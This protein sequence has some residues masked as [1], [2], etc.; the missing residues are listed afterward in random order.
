MK[1]KIST[2]SL[3]FASIFFLIG[4][5]SLPTLIASWDFS[6]YGNP[7]QDLVFLRDGWR[8]FQHNTP[9][10]S[11][12][13]GA[14]QSLV[15]AFVI[16]MQHLCGMFSDV[17]HIVPSEEELQGIF[18]SSKLT[19]FLLY[20]LLITIASIRV[21]YLTDAYT[22]LI[23]GC[24]IAVS[25]GMSV[26]IVQLRN[27]AYSSLF[28]ILAISQISIYQLRATRKSYETNINPS[29]LHGDIFVYIILSGLSVMAKVQIIPLFFLFCLGMSVL[30][31]VHS[32]KNRINA[33]LRS[34][35]SALA[36]STLVLLATKTFP[37]HLGRQGFVV[38]LF[39]IAVLLFP[40]FWITQLR[41]TNWKEDLSYT[42]FSIAIIFFFL[43]VF[44]ALSPEWV[45]TFLDFSRS[46]VHAVSG[47]SCSSLSCSL[48]LASDSIYY[49]FKRTFWTNMFSSFMGALIVCYFSCIVS[50]R[51]ESNRFMRL[52]LICI[53]ILASFLV[54]SLEY[55]VSG[56][57]ISFFGCIIGAALAQIATFNYA[58]LL[59]QKTSAFIFFCSIFVAVFCGL[60]W[61]ADHYLMFQQPFLV[62]GLV[63]EPSL[64]SFRS[65]QFI[66]FTSI[67]V[68]LF[69]IQAINLN[70]LSYTYQKS[71]DLSSPDLCAGQHQGIVWNRTF[72]SNL[73]CRLN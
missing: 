3:S 60:R 42:L 5:L 48:Q 10:Y 23:A 19:N 28:F 29:I 4:L 43:Y 44:S 17:Q 13:P 37:L 71:L 64:K 14:I 39:T 15:V 25:S 70:L 56:K 6:W 11:E 1:H 68:C 22:A 52:F 2:G 41:S 38:G 7:D 47:S 12:H 16:R 31:K 53:A 26:E 36:A 54:F 8:L 21:S 46:S 67:F 45:V 58:N 55:G 30:G 50:M 62:F 72:I 69:S 9:L 59:M 20:V 27:E 65:L 63:S 24:I 32:G 49:L 61:P 18:Q 40:V 35:I 51:I 57:L 34:G 33:V 73:N 66:L